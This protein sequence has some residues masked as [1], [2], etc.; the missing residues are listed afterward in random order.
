[1]TSAGLAGL[2]RLLDDVRRSADTA[3]ADVLGHLPDTGDHVTGR[4]VD[5]F[6]EQAADALRSLETVLA[7]TIHLVRGSEVGDSA[8]DGGEA[9]RDDGAGSGRGG[10]HATPRTDPSSVRPGWLR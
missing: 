10:T 3:A 2:V 9:P 8:P 1:M 4:A 7:D 6:V 5:D